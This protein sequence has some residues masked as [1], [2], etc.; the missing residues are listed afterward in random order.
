MCCQYICS[1][2]A[3]Q[4]AVFNCRVCQHL[5]LRQERHSRQPIRLNCERNLVPP[6]P[7]AITMQQTDPSRSARLEKHFGRKA[8]LEERT[9]HLDS[10]LPWISDWA[11]VY[12]TEQLSNGMLPF[13]SSPNSDDVPADITSSYVAAPPS[14]V[15]C[16]MYCQ[17]CGCG[18]DAPRRSPKLQGPPGRPGTPSTPHVY[19]RP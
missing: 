1:Q 6:G 5:S 4:S 9:A 18:K 17:R 13:D 16:S 19:A 11:T 7:L 2:A 8:K 15:K 14:Q 12:G 3:H 10:I